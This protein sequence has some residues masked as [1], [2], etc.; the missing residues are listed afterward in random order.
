[1]TLLAK[2][3]VLRKKPKRLVLQSCFKHKTS[4][5][6]SF[7]WGYLYP[8]QFRLRP[9]PLIRP[10]VTA[11]RSNGNDIA[12]LGDVVPQPFLN[13]ISKLHFV[14]EKTNNGV[15]VH[16]K[17][18]NGTSV[19]GSKVGKGR[20]KVIQH[21]EVIKLGEQDCYVFMRTESRYFT[22]FPKELRRKYMVSKQLGKGACGV[23]NLAFRKS[24][25]YRFAL[26]TVNKKRMRELGSK[27]PPEN[28]AELTKKADHSC[29]IKLYDRFQTE[30]ELY[31][32]LE[33]GEGGELF[34][35]VLE[36]RRL[37]EKEAKMYF[38]Q[39]TS[40]TS[41]NCG[42]YLFYPNFFLFQL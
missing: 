30:D 31:L 32:I 7:Q 19:N 40:G 21:N 17:S 27:V 34:D 10:R 16:D 29:I 36:Q 8:I 22:G 18:S 14:I 5:F 25:G 12:I 13:T 42:R 41:W 28:E 23:V 15:M 38:Y 33:Y 4:T 24:D 9:A 11:G 1:M 37:S 39:M 26:K 6:L 20:V 35:R 3:K 2:M